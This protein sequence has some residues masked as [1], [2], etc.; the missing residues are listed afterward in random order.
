MIDYVGAPGDHVLGSGVAAGHVSVAVG[1]VLKHLS[2]GVGFLHASNVADAEQVHGI[3][4][5][6]LY[7]AHD[8]GL[9]HV[10]GDQAHQVGALLLGEGQASHVGQVDGSVVHDDEELFRVVFGSLLG[11]VRQHPAHADDQIVFFVDEGVDVGLIVGV[12]PALQE[13]NLEFVFGQSLQARPGELVEG[14]VVDAANV[15]HHA[16][17][18]LFAFRHRG[19][20]QGQH[21]TQSQD[22]RENLFHFLASDQIDI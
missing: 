7:I 18:D 10:T 16:D 21:Q 11:G 5:H 22:G 8:V 1:I 20:G 14:L 17:L 4:H 9:G 13:L 2:V 19:S 15:G 6:A 3:R 12:S